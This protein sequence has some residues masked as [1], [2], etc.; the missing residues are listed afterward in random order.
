[1]ALLR[2]AKIDKISCPI[3]IF[4]LV[5]ICMCLTVEKNHIDRVWCELVAAALLYFAVFTD[6]L[7]ETSPSSPLPLSSS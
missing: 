7:S 5:M 2:C 1:M 6:F 3:F 4:Q